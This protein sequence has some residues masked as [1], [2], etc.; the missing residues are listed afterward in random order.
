MSNNCPLVAFAKSTRLLVRL[1]KSNLLHRANVLKIIFCIHKDTNPHRPYIR[2]KVVVNTLYLTAGLVVLLLGGE[3]LLRAAVAAATRWRVPKVVVG[4]TIV[5]FATSLPELITSIRAALE[6]YP[7]L[8]L[9]NVVGSNI[10]NLGFVLGVILLFGRIQVEKSFYRFDWPLV[11]GVSLLLLFLLYDGKI[12]HSDGVLLLLLLVAVMVYLIKFQPPVLLVEEAAPKETKTWLWI[13]AF[14]GLGSL[15]LAFGSQWLVQGAVGLARAYDVSER[16]IG[17][18]VVSIGTSLPE[19][20]A[21]GMAI[22]KKEQGISIG[23]LIGS[24]LFNIL[25]VLGVTA[26]IHPLQLV[27]EQLLTLDIWV[28]IGFAFLLLP[29]VFFPTRLQLSWREGLILL[30][31]YA[32]YMT[33]TL[34]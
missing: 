6:G 7:D 5:S 27:D 4:M 2:L 13:L 20:V 1:G 26:V 15:G 29:L 3:W 21:S 14:A 23:N 19:L 8:S 25:T 33:L 18:T 10:A 24:N 11:F 17:I 32:A 34:T 30:A 16:I 22:L 28:M 9:S 12:S 31:A